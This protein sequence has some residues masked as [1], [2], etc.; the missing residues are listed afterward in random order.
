MMFGHPPPRVSPLRGQLVQRLAYLNELLKGGLDDYFSI[1]TQEEREACKAQ[2]QEY[3]ARVEAL[4][5]RLPQTEDAP[6]EQVLMDV[7]VC[8]VEEDTG[9]AEWFTV[10]GPD[11]VDTATG[12]ISLLSPLGK[13]LLL[14]RVNEAVALNAPGGCYI[15]RVGAIGHPQREAR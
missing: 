2:I 6:A 15:Y 7:P 3:I 11:E 10:V 13:E 14:K 4:L 12:A 5:A 8:V 1:N 9:T